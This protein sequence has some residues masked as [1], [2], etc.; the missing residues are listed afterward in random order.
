MQ[1]VVVGSGYSGTPVANRVARKVK[2]AERPQVALTLREDFV[3]FADF[4]PR[5]LHIA[6][7][8]GLIDEL[9]AWARALAPLRTALVS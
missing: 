2:D 6:A 5:E 9:L 4:Q 8:H 7:V 3:N 1:V